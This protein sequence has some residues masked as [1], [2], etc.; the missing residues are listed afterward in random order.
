MN[1]AGREIS[2]GHVK[3]VLLDFIIQCHPLVIVITFRYAD[4]VSFSLAH[5]VCHVPLGG[6]RAPLAMKDAAPVSRTQTLLLGVLLRPA[7]CATRD[8]LDQPEARVP[9]VCR[10]STRKQVLMCAL[11]VLPARF[12]GVME[13]VYVRFAD[14][15]RSLQL[16]E[17]MPAPNAVQASTD[18]F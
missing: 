9:H 14:Q 3:L 1:M 5:R 11:T 2:D 10:A 12:L 13:K 7:V 16:Q 18:P 4:L 15:A 8:M 17:M 6:L